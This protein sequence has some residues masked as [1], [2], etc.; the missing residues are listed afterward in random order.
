[1]EALANQEAGQA[2]IVES[3]IQL[4]RLFGP[5]SLESSI[6]QSMQGEQKQDDIQAHAERLVHYVGHQ[7]AC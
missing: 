4:L 6:E 3:R 2:S 5:D 7:R 1:M